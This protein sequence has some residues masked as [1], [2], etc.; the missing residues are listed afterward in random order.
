MTAVLITGATGK[1]GGSVIKN[2]VARNAPFEILALTRNSASASSQRLAKLSSKIIL[3][4]G[5]L[6]N[7]AEIFQS[8]RLLTTSRIWGVFSV[9][10]AIGNTSN[11]E[12]QGKGLIDE[13]LRQGVEFFIYSSVDRGGEEAS[14]N[15][16]TNV[17]HFIHKHNIEHH[18][19]DRADDS[20]MDWTILRPTAFFDNLVPGFYGKAF[21][22]SWQVSLKDKPLQLVATSDIGYFAADAFLKPEEYKGKGV[23]LAGDEL[24]YDEM[25]HIF[26]EKTGQ[27]VPTT[28]RFLC[29][30]FLASMKDFGYMFKWFHDEGY[31]ANIPKLRET[32][33]ELKDF[34][35]WL[36]KE[37]QFMKR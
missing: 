28:F 4:E 7:P 11:E 5:N 1:Q 27:P 6:D 13:S 33:P 29:S 30:I 17:P 8:A 22:T 23:S 2:L 9:L 25:A 20:N 32:Y 19:V 16:P 34:G 10:V 15:N 12:Q 26:Q 18:L 31:K 35:S 21:A 37:S 24:T 36:E 14:F 3:I